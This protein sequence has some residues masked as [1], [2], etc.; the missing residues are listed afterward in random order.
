MVRS[1]AYPRESLDKA[2][3]QELARRPVKGDYVL[4]DEVASLE[5]P[6]ARQELVRS[7]NALVERLVTF[8]RS[9]YSLDLTVDEATSALNGYVDVYGA[10]IALSGVR[11][12]VHD[13]NSSKDVD[14]VVH[15]FVERIIETDPDGFAYLE[16]VVQGSM[17]ATVLYLPDPGAH[18]RKFRA[19]TVYLDTP[20][21]LRAMGHCGSELRSPALELIK[22]LRDYGARVACF[23]HTLSETQGVLLGAA[24]AGGRH[25]KAH[26]GLTEVGTHFSQTGVTPGDVQVL[27]GRLVQDLTTMGVSVLD[28][29]PHVVALTVDEKALEDVLREEVNYQ[30]DQPL[31][32]DLNSLAAIH[33]LRKG[34]SPSI[35]EHSGAILVTTNVALVRAS[36]KAFRPDVGGVSWPPAILDS[37]LATLMWL[38]QPMRAPNLPRNQI[39][40]DCYAALR[41]TPAVWEGYLFE[42]E[43]LRSDGSV[44]QA[45]IDIMRFSP[46]AQR[47]LMDR[48]FGQPAAVTPE[49][50]A[51]VLSSARSTLTS[52]LDAKIHELTARLDETN[53]QRAASDEE[54]ARLRRVARE[55]EA[56]AR[57]LLESD[58]Q[59]FARVVATADRGAVKV[60]LW[61]FWILFGGVL[62]L[63]GVGVGA[64]LRW[65][66]P[67]WLRAVAIG[68][69]LLAA[70]AG[71]AI[72]ADDLRSARWSFTDLYARRRRKRALRRLG[73]TGSSAWPLPSLCRPG[74]DGTAATD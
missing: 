68:A 56:K 72:G 2:V 37:D 65:H 30:R 5:M 8:A 32:H 35:L 44:T 10:P 6:R 55:A 52:P 36:R 61:G 57:D 69:A 13:C 25:P 46:H 4:A 63:S 17:L 12:L 38:K 28:R 42:I 33:R 62:V 66:G 20:F 24:N 34:R 54:H 64:L 50:V 71:V 67:L 39:V 53:A 41:P 43:K 27:V 45:D 21:L 3:H 7:Q 16:R 40:A 19:V 26:R 11:S 48:T 70:A 51:E 14:Y 59:Q 47:A 22:L 49:T 23:D 1:A 58:E 15:A 18:Q 73:Y 31:L 9:A 29:P 60:G 74:I